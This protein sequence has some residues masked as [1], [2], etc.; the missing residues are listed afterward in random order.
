M[1]GNSF[2]IPA[3]EKAEESD[4]LKSAFLKNISHEVRTPM[5]GILGF[6]GLLSPDNDKDDQE[7]YINIIQQSTNQLLNIVNDIIAISKIETN[8]EEVNFTSFHPYNLIKDIYIDYTHLKPVDEKRD[9]DFKMN[10]SIHPDLTISSD[11]SKIQRILGILLD[12]SFKFTRQGVVE[13]GCLLD[14]DRIVFFVK[15]TGCGI[16]DDK[17]TLILKSFTQADEETVQEFGGA[18]LGLTI[19]V[20]YLKL[21]NS[22]LIINSN[23]HEGTEIRFNLPIPGVG[24]GAPSESISSQSIQTSQNLSEGS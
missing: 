20:G 3:K 4:R 16:P 6:T 21:L 2:S 23:L 24:E 9:V 11:L 10:L 5:N 8:Q 13:I 22:S 17:Q 7:H 18:G 19:A 14:N 12:N 15:D 1:S